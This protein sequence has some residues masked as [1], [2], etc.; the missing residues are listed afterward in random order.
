MEKGK[1]RFTVELAGVPIE[2]VCAHRENY[3]FFREYWSD[4]TPVERCEYSDLHFDT[5]KRVREAVRIEEGL[6]SATLSD[7]C[8]EN[9]TL[10]WRLGEALV[11]RDVLQ[12]YGSALSMDGVAYVFTA[13]SGTGK[14][15]H[16]RFWRETFGDRVAMINDDRPLVKIR[17]DGAV[18]YGSPWTGKHKLGRNISA[19]LKAIVWLTR[20]EENRIERITPTQAFPVVF[21][22]AHNSSVVEQLRRIMELERLLLRSTPCFKLTCNLNPDAAIVAR[23]GIRDF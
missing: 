20:G 17:E 14:S 8:V 5:V 3:E 4:K 23:T 10:D 1:Y 9:L 13:P 22:E 2:V 6:T 12:F 21:R 18:V 15:T 19:P 7:E 16:A 11:A